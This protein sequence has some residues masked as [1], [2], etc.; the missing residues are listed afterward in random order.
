MPNHFSALKRLAQTEKR[1]A[2]N[3]RN[4]GVLRSGLREIREELARKD[5]EKAR[6]LMREACSRIDKSVQKGAIHKNRAARL[7]SRL[8][9]RWNALHSGT[10][11]A[12]T[13]AKPQ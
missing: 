1:T 3:R 8:M 9:A 11:A 6:P 7:K 2:A 12:T 13:P 4:K 5:A 10:G